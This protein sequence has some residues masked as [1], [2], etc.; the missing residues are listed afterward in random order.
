MLPEGAVGAGDPE[1]D[2]EIV[3]LHTLYVSTHDRDR[4]ATDV[5]GLA[6][7]GSSLLVALN[8]LLLKRAQVT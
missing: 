8:A 4:R 7:S 3:G 2:A 5:L 6:M 1:V